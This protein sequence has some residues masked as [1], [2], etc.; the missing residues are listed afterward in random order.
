MAVLGSVWDNG[1]LSFGQM[2]PEEFATDPMI[3]AGVALWVGTFGNHSSP[4]LAPNL[5]SGTK[6]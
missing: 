5:W 4:L 3:K 6:G 1:H 2:E